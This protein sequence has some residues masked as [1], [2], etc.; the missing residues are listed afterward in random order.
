[1]PIPEMSPGMQIL[2]TFVGGAIAYAL[3]Y[4]SQI[5]KNNSTVV[6][7]DVVVPPMALMDSQAL[8]EAARTLRESS[9]G[10]MERDRQLRDM[11]KQLQLHTEQLTDLVRLGSSRN[12][13]LQELSEHLTEVL[14]REG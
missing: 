12:R 9:E 10:N 1:M 8:R 7:K 11:Q 14:R 4:Y 3:H 13:M 6:S 5:K 2:V